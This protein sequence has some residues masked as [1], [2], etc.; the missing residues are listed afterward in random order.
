[1][2]PAAEV[3]LHS[4]L[5]PVSL[6]WVTGETGISAWCHAW[7]VRDHHVAPAGRSRA[8]SGSS[9]R[10]WMWSRL[11][12]PWQLFQALQW[13]IHPQMPPLK[14]TLA[15]NPREKGFHWALSVDNRKL[16]VRNTIV[17]GNANKFHDRS[18]MELLPNSQVGP[19]AC[20]HPLGT[21][22][23]AKFWW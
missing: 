12:P 22:L 5:L 17:W 4:E 1:M 11:H 19:A 2:P 23:E 20:H 8:F 16:Q 21:I 10:V 7:A 3:D 6:G 9:A 14:E 15:C 13:S 18:P